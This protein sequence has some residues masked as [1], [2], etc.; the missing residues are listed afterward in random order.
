MSPFFYSSDRSRTGT[1]NDAIRRRATVE[2]HFAG[3]SRF[4]ARA[5][6]CGRDFSPE[7]SLLRTE[8]QQ[9]GYAVRGDLLVA[10]L[11]RQIAVPMWQVPPLH[12]IHSDETAEVTLLDV[13]RNVPAAGEG[14]CAVVPRVQVST[15]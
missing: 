12:E 6:T 8:H 10:L 15:G 2:S 9:H 3:F 5:E 11:L 1:T 7:I 14:Y 13:R 4:S